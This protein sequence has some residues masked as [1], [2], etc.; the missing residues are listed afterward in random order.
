VLSQGLGDLW[1]TGFNIDWQK[2]YSGKKRIRVPL[3][4]YPFEKRSYW[5]N[6][7]IQGA[8]ESRY[9]EGDGV[10]SDRTKSE[11]EQLEILQKKVSGVW[12]E[13]LGIEA[14]PDDDFFDIGGDSLI[15]GRMIAKLNRMLQID[16]SSSIIFEASTIRQL[17][18]LIEEALITEIQQQQ[19]K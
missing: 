7:S 9:S 16:L 12:Y 6:G 8:Q 10:E 17:T 1:A 5:I 15:G 4:T 11:E 19:S 3:P 13:L 2:Y 14:G 18:L